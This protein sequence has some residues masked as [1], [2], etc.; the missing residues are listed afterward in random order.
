MRYLLDYYIHLP[1]PA[2]DGKS[3]SHAVSILSKLRSGEGLA[4]PGLLVIM[5][6][7]SPPGVSRGSSKDKGR[8]GRI[9]IEGR[10]FALFQL[11]PQIPFVSLGKQGTRPGHGRFWGLGDRAQAQSHATLPCDLILARVAS[12]PCARR[13]TTSPCCSRKLEKERNLVRRGGGAQHVEEYDPTVP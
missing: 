13:D 10:V 3:Q 12:R 9:H 11:L 7:P 8:E 6:R 4:R 1:A 2:S 5:S